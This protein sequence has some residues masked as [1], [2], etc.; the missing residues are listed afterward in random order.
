MNILSDPLFCTLLLFTF[1]AVVKWAEH[2][3][4]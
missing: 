3:A 2:D 4:R 1:L